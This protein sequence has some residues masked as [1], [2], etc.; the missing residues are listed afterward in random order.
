MIA[1]ANLQSSRCS[2]SLD[3]ILSYLLMTRPTSL[4]LLTRGKESSPFEEE[5]HRL[6]KPFSLLRFRLSLLK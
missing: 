3:M 5:L 4:F 1:K 2:L 6:E